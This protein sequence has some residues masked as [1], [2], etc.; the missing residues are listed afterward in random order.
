MRKNVPS[1]CRQ[2]APVVFI[3]SAPKP[4]AGYPLAWH[5]STA[6]PSSAPTTNGPS[7]FF[8]TCSTQLVMNSCMPSEPNVTCDRGA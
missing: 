1:S 4:A 5:K 6:P 8:C 7:C 3:V 2:Y